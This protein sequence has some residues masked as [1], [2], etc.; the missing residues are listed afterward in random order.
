[1]NLPRDPM[2]RITLLI[3]LAGMA[4]MVIS[5]VSLIRPA[6]PAAVAL[7]VP[8]DAPASQVLSGPPFTADGNLL[9]NPSFENDLNSDGVADAWGRLGPA[10]FALDASARYGD[11]AQRVT[12]RGVADPIANFGAVQQHVALPGEGSFTISIDYRYMLIGAPDASRAVGITIYALA[13]DNSYIANGT[14]TDWGWSPTESWTRK[15]IRLRPPT[16]TAKLIVEFRVSVN[17]T[18]WLDGAKLER[19][20]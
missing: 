11:H 9:L 18:L 13:R 8:V 12:L 7:P 1:M 17:G 3:V 16:G 19:V 15:G 4:A 6:T 20:P 14:T 2:D 5:L 10:E